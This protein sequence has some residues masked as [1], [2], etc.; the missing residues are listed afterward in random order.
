[1]G[2]MSIRML[3]LVLT[4]FGFAQVWLGGSVGQPGAPGIALA[5]EAS[6]N[7][8]GLSRDP[9]AFRSQVDQIIRHVD[10]LLQKLKENQKARGAVL[11]LMQTRDNVLRE[12]G[13]VENT[14]DG[15]KWKSGE[16]RESV[17]LMLRLLKT[18][19]EKAAQSA[20]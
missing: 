14:P 13:K 7:V 19:Y 15:A 12:I 11:D 3:A 17:E 4:P 18:Q 2:W 8:E 16:A 10:S 9:K 20:D 6:L 5:A 1:M